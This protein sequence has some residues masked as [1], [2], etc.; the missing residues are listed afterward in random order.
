LPA[1]AFAKN[2]TFVGENFDLKGLVEDMLQLDPETNQNV[3]QGIM[4]NVLTFSG[5]LVGPVLT[6]VWSAS[7][8]NGYAERFK[9]VIEPRFGLQWISPYEQRNLIVPIEYGIDSMVTGTTNISYSL[10]N[11]LLARRKMPVGPSVVRDVLAVTIA[12][13]H[14]SDALAAQYDPNYLLG[15]ASPYSALSISSTVTPTDT[16]PIGGL[17]LPVAVRG[18]VVGAATG[19][20]ARTDGPSVPS[21]V[22]TTTPPSTAGSIVPMNVRP[23]ISGLGW[24]KRVPPGDITTTNETFASRRIR[25]ASGCSSCA[26]SGVASAAWTSGVAATACATDSTRSSA[27]WRARRSAATRATIT[28]DPATSSRTAA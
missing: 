5:D 1:D 10:T 13:S 14:Y 27:P 11:R 25:S 23:I 2:A 26:G 16:R 6:K 17:G 24:L 7:P 4:R 12:Q 19:T 15:G 3:S 22:S 28:P 18:A 20:T 21:K 8:T 9:H